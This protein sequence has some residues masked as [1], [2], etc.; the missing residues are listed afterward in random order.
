MN[1]QWLKPSKS[2]YALSSLLGI[3]TGIIRSYDVKHPN[4]GWTLLTLILLGVGSIFVA[5]EFHDEQQL[6]IMK[7]IACTI[8]LAVSQ[9]LTLQALTYFVDRL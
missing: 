7:F 1:L 3:V 4:L 2:A 9:T 6:P 5:H 8:C